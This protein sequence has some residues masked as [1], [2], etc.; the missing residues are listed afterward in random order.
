MIPLYAFLIAWLA[1][2]GIYAIMA[3]LSVIQMVRFGIANVGTYLSTVLFLAV[4]IVVLLG[5]GSTLI[6]IDWHQQLNAFG[7]LG[8][9]SIF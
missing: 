2:I 3:L 7:W 5:T 1:F 6:G 9:T 8:S 4:L